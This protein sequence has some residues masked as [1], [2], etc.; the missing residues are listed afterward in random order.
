MKVTIIWINHN[1]RHSIEKVFESL[2]CVVKQ[3]FSDYELVIVDDGSTDGSDKMIRN[4]IKEEKLYNEIPELKIVK[5]S[6]SYGFTG[7]VNAGYRVRS[8][9]SKYVVVHNN[10][11]C[12][13]KD[14]LD[15]YVKVMEENEDIGALQGI[16]LWA[17]D[18]HIV[19]SAGGYLVLRL[20]S[21]F[22][23]IIHIRGIKIDVLQS[24]ISRYS[25]SIG[26]PITFFEGTLPIIR[27]ESVRKI[28]GSYGEQSLFITS[29]R[30]YYLEDVL[31]SLLLWN[32]GFRVY[33]YNK[34]VGH[35]YRGIVLQTIGRS[36]EFEKI[37]KRNY[38]VLRTLIV[39]GLFSRYYSL[40]LDL[41]Y[42]LRSFV[43]SLKRKS[44]DELCS[45]ANGI[46]LYIETRKALHLRKLSM[47][48]V[49]LL[50]QLATK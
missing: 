17:Y 33:L 47:K 26:I 4:F 43:R 8:N 39:H 44:V 14:T 22:L 40:L 28:L 7:A 37:I 42:V 10:D 45:I 24:L 21:S 34:P 2:Y 19:D 46:K 16:I 11:A 30:F 41:I 48:N 23:D 32:T 18:K 3:K 20:P 15:D 1:S 12:M 5:L 38:F 36:R 6:K 49:P 9:N 31:L 29:A 27:I 50:L 35:H 13:Y 25:D